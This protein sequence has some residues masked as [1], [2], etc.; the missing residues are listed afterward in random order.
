MTKKGFDLKAILAGVPKRVRMPALERA[1]DPNYVT[2]V[3][4]NSAGGQWKYRYK[5]TEAK[6]ACRWLERIYKGKG[7]KC[8]IEE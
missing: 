6:A 1:G 3:F 4:T 7:I 2:I 8:E 5:R